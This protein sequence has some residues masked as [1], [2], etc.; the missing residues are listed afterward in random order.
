MFNLSW[1]ATA[2]NPS[3]KESPMPETE[4]DLMRAAIKAHNR[5]LAALERNCHEPQEIEPRVIRALLKFGLLRTYPGHD[6]PLWYRGT[7]MIEDRSIWPLIEAQVGVADD[8]PS[9]PPA[10]GFAPIDI[11]EG[12]SLDRIADLYGVEPP[13]IPGETDTAF[14][15]RLM[16]W[17]GKYRQPGANP[18]AAPQSGAF[19]RQESLVDDQPEPAAPSVFENWIKTAPDAALDR[20]APTPPKPGDMIKTTREQS[21]LFGQTLPKDTVGQI[22]QCDPDDVLWLADFG[23]LGARFTAPDAIEII[24]R[25]SKDDPFSALKAVIVRFAPSGAIIHASTPERNAFRRRLRAA[26]SEDADPED[27]ESFIAEF[28]ARSVDLGPIVRKIVEV[29][30]IPPRPGSTVGHEP[31]MITLVERWEELYD[32]PDTH[33]T[34][35]AI[36]FARWYHAHRTTGAGKPK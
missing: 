31:D 26:L 14:R 22:I 15:W 10:T 9:P 32:R 34:D 21:G 28:D 3:P 12:R 33:P 29:E 30:T 25:R 11:C 24:A 8:A 19:D 4:L 1:I 7:G 18:P 13:R 20:I 6:G 2:N 23:E 27:F 5:R 35:D 36:A 16:E 17:I